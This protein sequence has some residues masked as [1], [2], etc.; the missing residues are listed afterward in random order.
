MR[1]AVG[2]QSRRRSSTPPEHGEGGKTQEA[3]RKARWLRDGAAI[4][5]EA[6]K[7]T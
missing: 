2:L 1:W 7:Q 6:L 5:H 3:K 4:K